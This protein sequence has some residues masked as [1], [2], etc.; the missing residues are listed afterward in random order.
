MR[1]IIAFFRDYFRLM[2]TGD[3]FSFCNHDWIEKDYRRHCSKCDTH[4][5]MY[6]N[7]YPEVGQAKYEWH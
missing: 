1:S 3:P 2:K 4:Q 7:K 6:E 5:M